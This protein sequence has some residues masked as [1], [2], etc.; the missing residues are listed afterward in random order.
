M[1]EANELD[2]AV[3]E[4]AAKMD[5]SKYKTGQFTTEETET[6]KAAVR[7]YCAVKGV[8]VERLC[9]ECKHKAELKG[10]WMEIAKDIPHRSVQSVYRH[11]L[12]QLHPFKRGKWSDE[13]VEQLIHH[14]D[15]LGKKWATIQDKLNR[16]ADACRDKWREKSEDFQRGRWNEK[17]MEEL[18]NLVRQ[19]VKGCAPDA[20][21]SKFQFN[22][23]TGEESFS[24]IEA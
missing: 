20:D 4:A 14:V 12:R 6:I 11:G 21:M 17:E 23:S 24:S 18:K 22:Q 15:V 10:A 16:S 9:S 2:L 8:S 1:A 3:E 19:H 7:R 13:E 5:S